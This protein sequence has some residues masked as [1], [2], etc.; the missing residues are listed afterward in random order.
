MH[1]YEG[2][3]NVA[4]PKLCGKPAKFI[5][6]IDGGLQLMCGRH[7]NFWAVRGFKVSPLEDAT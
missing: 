2:G 6:V 1:V 7:G 3:Q 5:V 4:K